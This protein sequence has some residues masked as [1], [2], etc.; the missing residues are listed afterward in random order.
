MDNDVVDFAMQCPLNLKL[1]HLNK[2]IGMNENESIN[3]KNNYYQKT[4]EGK[5]I[6]RD[7]MKSYLPNT[8]TSGSKQGFS[9]P[10]ATWFRKQSLDFLKNNILQKDA[11]I[12]NYFDTKTINSL[13]ESHLEGK[14]NR[15]L[16]IWSLLNFESYL[17]LYGNN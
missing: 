1:N 4:K 5:Q 6:L 9:S 8:I 2:I 14:T 10:D 16:F 11:R 12:T 15:R 17:E 13:V 3:K 7:V